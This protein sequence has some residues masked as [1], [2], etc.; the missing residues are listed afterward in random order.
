[1]GR[2]NIFLSLILRVNSFRIKSC[3]S[4]AIDLRAESAGVLLAH[5]SAVYAEHLA[6]EVGLKYNMLSRKK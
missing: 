4:A 1:M 2:L 6:L 3:I 5:T